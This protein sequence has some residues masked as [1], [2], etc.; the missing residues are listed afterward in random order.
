MA[1]NQPA[2]ITLRTSQAEE[3]LRFPSKFQRK[4][5]FLPPSPSFPLY[6][7]HFVR[8]LPT[9]KSNHHYMTE[10]CF[11]ERSQKQLQSGTY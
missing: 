8:D 9:L 4:S 1:G 7:L 3:T 5:T 10:W 11:R 2:V 6:I